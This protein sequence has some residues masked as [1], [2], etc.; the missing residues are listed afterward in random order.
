VAWAPQDCI[1][2]EGAEITA[3][4]SLSARF[5]IVGSVLNDLAPIH[6]GI[7]AAVASNRH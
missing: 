4:K 6:H 5:T 2:I 7:I 3:A 1:T